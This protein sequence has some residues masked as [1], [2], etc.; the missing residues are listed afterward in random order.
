MTGLLFGF[1][2]CAS[3]EDPSDVEDV[4]VDVDRSAVERGRY[5]AIVAGC[6]DCHSPKVF[7][8]QQGA[9]PDASRHLGGHVSAQPLPDRPP[10]TLGPNGWG[11][12]VSNDFTG[13]I[14]R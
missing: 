11:A 2:G 7:T 14:A 6:A 13:T 8:P 4:A 5:L 1:G 10:A 9:H 3:G 12:L